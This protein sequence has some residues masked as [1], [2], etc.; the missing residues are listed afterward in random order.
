L[1]FKA[2]QAR[3]GRKDVGAD[4]LAQTPVV[5]VAY[6]LL[7]QN[8]DVLLDYPLYQRR[9][10]ME[11]LIRCSGGE[12]PLEGV[13]KSPVVPSLQLLIKYV[14]RIDRLFDDARAR[15]NEGLMVKDPDSV[16]KPGRRGREWLKIKKAL[17]TLDVVVTA[18]E[19]GSG[20]RRRFLSDYTFAVRRSA[21][22]PT[23]LNVG[24]AYSGLTDA[25][26]Q[27]LTDWFREHTLQD[28]GRVK[29]VEP[30]IVLEVAFDTVQPS[31]RHKSGYALRFPRI[32]SWRRDKPASEIDTLDT[33]RQLANEGDKVTR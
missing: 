1:S 15:N 12:Q 22:D 17:A 29:L 7:Y 27:E 9:V 21:D 4:L 26:V 14:D 28:F 30:Q 13:I 18:A 3:L 2:L 11:D 24:K 5:F 32:I 10:R 33:V 23:L 19:V 25:E 31:A 8:D 6:D 20:N 16:Y